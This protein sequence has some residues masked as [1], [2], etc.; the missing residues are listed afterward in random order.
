V[1]AAILAYAETLCAEVARDPRLL[2]EF[3][4]IIALALETLRQIAWR[5]PA[6]S[7]WAGDRRTLTEL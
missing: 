5:T 6:L 1:Q 2:S 3:V 4:V 7:T